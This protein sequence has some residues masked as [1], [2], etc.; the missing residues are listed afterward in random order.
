MKFWEYLCRV[1]K[2]EIQYCSCDAFPCPFCDETFDSIF[3]TQDWNVHLDE[4]HA[5][6]M[7]QFDSIQTNNSSQKSG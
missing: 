2:R 6:V 7:K 5:E 4:K 3:K 1:C